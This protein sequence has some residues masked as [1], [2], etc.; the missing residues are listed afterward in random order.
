M[1]QN[2]YFSEGAI[3]CRTAGSAVRPCLQNVA[4]RTNYS[5]S[6]LLLRV[7][8]ELQVAR[9]RRRR[10]RARARTAP[11]PHGRARRPPSRRARRPP[12]RRRPAA[13]PAACRSSGACREA[14]SA[15][16]SLPALKDFQR[17]RIGTYGRCTRYDSTT[18]VEFRFLNVFKTNVSTFQN[19]DFRVFRLGHK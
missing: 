2:A 9:I 1:L 16:A 7:I 15:E 18:I 10:P 12:A 6:A 14:S 3:W 17:D 19:F 11:V 5:N 8:T 13:V 4:G